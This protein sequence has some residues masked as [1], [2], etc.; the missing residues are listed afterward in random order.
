[1]EY[2]CVKCGELFPY[3]PA[4]GCNECG[5]SRFIRI[6]NID[7]AQKSAVICCGENAPELSTLTKDNVIPI[8]NTFLSNVSYNGSKSHLHIINVL[9]YMYKYI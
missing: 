3:D 4:G 9:N 5:S 6:P 2:K 1:M 7:E 8:R